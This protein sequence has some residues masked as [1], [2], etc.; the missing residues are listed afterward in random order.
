M[1]VAVAQLC[2][3]PERKAATLASGGLYGC[4][5]NAV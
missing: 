5:G 2:G 3:W 1:G 4:H